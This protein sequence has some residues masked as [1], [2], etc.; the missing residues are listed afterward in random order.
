MD[1][2]SLTN[3][4]AIMR[5]MTN[6]QAGLDT[7]RNVINRLGGAQALSENL[8]LRIADHI[9]EQLILARQVVSNSSMRPE[10]KVGVQQIISGLE[11][12]FSITYLQSSWHQHIMNLP[13][14]ISSFVILLDAAGIPE[15]SGVPEEASELIL[16]INKILSAINDP[17]LDPVVRSVAE[18]HLLI[19]ATFL[20]HI[21]VFGLEG[22][23]TSYFEL[24]TRIRRAEV[25]SSPEA[26]AKFEPVWKAM[27][28]WSER[29]GSIDKVWNAGARVIQH[30][31]KATGLLD[32]IPH[33]L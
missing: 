31:D 22:A 32:Y 25:G 8:V 2:Q 7:G 6:G 9:L 20:K 10:A 23:M 28:R 11:S 29:L 12:A 33:V 5:E 17:E 24:M 16:D 30:A 19:L 1:T 4:L 15:P 26:K 21:P 3:V 13:G 18:K 14:A 27:T